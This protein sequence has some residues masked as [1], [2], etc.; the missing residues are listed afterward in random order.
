MT[1]R[2]KNEPFF[3]HRACFR[4]SRLLLASLDGSLGDLATSLVSLD[5]RLDDTDS[6]GL[7]HVTDG[8]TTK[9]WVVS[10]SLNTHWLGWNHLDDS[11]ITR[12]DELGAGFNRLAGTTINLLKKLRELASDV[13]S[14]AVQDWSVTGTNLTWVVEDDD[15]SVERIGTLWWIVLGVTGNVT[16]T[17]LLDGDVLDVETNVVTWN[18]LGELFVV[19]LDGLDLSGDVGW[20]ESNN[21]T[22]LDDTGFNTTDWH[23]ADTRDLVNILKWETER[24]VG[25]TGRWVDTIN[26]LKKSLARDI[27]TLLGSLGPSLV[28]WA[29][30]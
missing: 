11:G 1:R 24:L 13:S 25:W 30:G 21:H 20:G 12:L 6:N 29:V 27:T 28:P 7:S 17:N 8:E 16:T 9:R 18:T 15:L 4:I 26:G 5:N 22:G 14:V 10:E 19:H 2:R 23:R 3:I